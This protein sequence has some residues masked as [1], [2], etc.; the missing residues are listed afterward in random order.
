M[1]THFHESSPLTLATSTEKSS[2]EFQ[3]ISKGKLADTFPC[4][5]V[6]PPKSDGK[7]IPSHLFCSANVIWTNDFGFTFG[8]ELALF[9]H[10]R[11]GAA[12]ETRKKASCGL[13]R[14]FLF[15]S[16][17]R[18]KCT[19]AVCERRLVSDSLICTACCLLWCSRHKG[20]TNKHRHTRTHTH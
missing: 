14:T 18:P 5:R 1:H 19:W 13:T 2:A 9:G 17:T 12:G 3:W 4:S 8:I 20:T 10:R 6:A 15:T 16:H 11:K 7:E